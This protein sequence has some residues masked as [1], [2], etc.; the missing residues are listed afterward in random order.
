MQRYLQ[1]H[2]F[3]VLEFAAFEE[4]PGEVQQHLCVLIFVEFL[5]AVLI[6]Q[7]RIEMLKNTDK[8][9]ATDHN[10]HRADD[11]APSPSAQH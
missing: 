9:E 8:G 2:L 1:Q 7:S 5:Q 6:L 11:C 10:I 4:R 3:A